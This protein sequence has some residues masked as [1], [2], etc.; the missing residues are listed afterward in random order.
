[1]KMT[2][3]EDANTPPGPYLEAGAQ[4]TWDYRI[5]N[6]GNVPLSN[7]LVIDDAGTP[8]ETG[9]D[10]P[11]CSLSSLAVGAAHTCSYS[12]TAQLGQYVNI[13]TVSADGP[14]AD[15]VTGSDLSHYFGAQAG[16]HLAKRV[17]GL[18]ADIP[19]GP[20]VLTGSLVLQTYEVENTGNVDLTDIQVRDDYG[21][22]GN[23]ADDI[24]I[25]TIAL[26]AA[27]ASDSCSISGTAL[28]GQQ[29]GNGTATGT[30]PGDLADVS[31]SDS[32]YYFGAQPDLLLIKRTN[33]EDADTAPGPYIL[34]GETVNWSYLLF[35]DGNVP[36]SNILLVDDPGTPANPLD[37][38]QVC[39][40]QSLLPGF[41]QT[42]YLTG[43]AAPG[44]YTNTGLATASPPGGLT[45]IQASDVSLYFG[46][47][48]AVQLTK[49]VNGVHAPAPPGPSLIIGE[50]VTW[51]YQVSNTGNVELTDL[52]VIDD[53][54][55]PGD[56]SDDIQ[57]CSFTLLAA[58]ADHTC[59]WSGVVV[60]GLYG[61]TARVT[62]DYSGQI[63]D[64]D[65]SYYTG[66]PPYRKIFLPIT[67]KGSG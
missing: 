29:A 41:S 5:T 58:G 46:A 31:D 55:T 50:Q 34:S 6:I 7:L 63:S 45:A 16:I 32:G 62:A 19:P 67:F 43:I 1:M 38:R 17:N 53:N 51:T 59:E 60:E 54:G 18:E 48:P 13:A 24:A 4:V 27:G 14:G 26:L 20:Y 42:C 44:Q 33:G 64:M 35:N 28:N 52:E 47:N 61:N 66:A 15:S 49:R 65:F 23:P 9:D 12:G 22:P 10:I 37:D 21:T 56:T 40:L 39:T 36:L 8:S 3:G 30:P 11:V 57:V 25:C 2:R